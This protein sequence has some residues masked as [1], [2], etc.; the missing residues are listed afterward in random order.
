MRISDRSSD[1]CSSDLLPG[2]SMDKLAFVARITSEPDAIIVSKDAPYK[3]LDDLV[4]AAKA[5][6]GTVKVAIQEIGSRTHLAMLRLQSMTDTQFKLIAYP[7]GAAPQK[8][9]LLSGETQIAITSLGDFATLIESG[10]A[11]GL[12]ERSE[13][14]TSELQSLMRS[15]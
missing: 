5:S 9:A 13:E 15:S 8:E 2:Y 1:V 12:V 11:R 6:P 3:T 7:G 10:D 4:K 14:H